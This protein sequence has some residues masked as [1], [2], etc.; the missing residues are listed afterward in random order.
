MEKTLKFITTATFLT[1]VIVIALF[2]SIVQAQQS[3]V[4]ITIRVHNIK[5]FNLPK[6]GGTITVN[7]YDENWK[8]LMSSSI[9]FQGGESYVTTSFTIP[10]SFNPSGR[11]WIE[12]SQTPNIGLKLTEYW[13]FKWIDTS[14][15]NVVEF[16][17]C[18]PYIKDIQLSKD[19]VSIGEEFTVTVK[20]K[21]PNYAKE[22][23][24]R[25]YFK[26]WLI[27]D[28]SKSYPYDYDITSGEYKIYYG[29]EKSIK[30]KLRLEKEGTYY[31]YAVLKGRWHWHSKNW[32]DTDQWVWYPSIEVIP[33]PGKLYVKLTSYDDDYHA[34]KVYID[35][36]YWGFVDSHPG[37]IKYSIDKEVSPG[38]HTVEIK[39]HDDDT[40][41]D[42]SKSLRKYVGSGQRIEYSFTIDEHLSSLIIKVFRPDHNTIIAGAKIV[43][44]TKDWHPLD[45]EYTDSRGSYIFYLKDGTYHAEVYYRDEFLGWVK[46]NNSYDIKVGNKGPVSLN[47]YQCLPNC[48]EQRHDIP[49]VIRG[50]PATMTIR[51][52]NFDSRQWRVKVYVI[53][54]KDKKA[55]WDNEGWTSEKVLKPGEV[56]EFKYT[57]TLAHYG[58]YYIWYKVYTYINNKWI[59]TDQWPWGLSFKVRGPDLI[60]EKIEV[61]GDRASGH[62]LTIRVTVKNI[63][64]ETAYNFYTNI[65]VDNRLFWRKNDKLEPGKS[66]TW[67]IPGIKDNKLNFRL[68]TGSYKIKAV[69]DAYNNSH[70]ENEDNNQKEYQ[71]TI[72]KAKWTIIAYL[73]AEAWEKG[74]ELDACLNDIISDF[75][76][77]GSN[78]YLTI[79]VLADW[80]GNGD[81]KCLFIGHNYEAI[82]RQNYE[83]NM[84][85]PNTLKDFL[86]M[87]REKFEAEKY[88]MV[89]T[90]HGGGS[91]F[92]CEKYPNS[93]DSM[94]GREFRKA[95]EEAKLKIDVLYIESCLM[96]N[97]DF[98]YTIA[99]S[100]YVK[101]LIASPILHPCAK[102]DIPLFADAAGPH[103]IVINYL[104]GNPDISPSNLASYIVDT[105]VHNWN[106]IGKY[107]RPMILVALDL[108]KIN[109]II[110]SLDNLARELYEN[111]YK[112]RTKINDANSSIIVYTWGR[113]ETIGTANL[114]QILDELEKHIDNDYVRSLIRSTRNSLNYAII[115][116]RGRNIRDELKG[117]FINWHWH[118]LPS[119][120]LSETYW[121]D[122]LHRQ[123]RSSTVY[124][125]FKD[126]DTNLFIKPD[127]CKVF[128]INDSKLIEAKYANV[129]ILDN[130]IVIENLNGSRLIPWTYKVL[131]YKNGFQVGEGEFRVNKR[132]STLNLNIFSYRRIKLTLITDYVGEFTC[133]S[134]SEI[135][136]KIYNHEGRLLYQG[137]TD[138][139][140]KIV[141]SLWP[142][143]HGGE[144]YKIEIQEVKKM[145]ENSRH[146]FDKWSDNARDIL[147][148]IK[149][150]QDITLVAHYKL[151]YYL[152]VE[153]PYGKVNGEGWYDRGS[154]AYVSLDKRIYPD[155][156]YG[157]NT[158]YVFEKWIDENT[159]EEFGNDYKK[160]KSI[161]MNKPRTIKAIWKPW[162]KLKVKTSPDISVNI[163][164]RYEHKTYTR[165]GEFIDFFKENS[166]VIVWT[167]E[168]YKTTNT[169]YK[170]REWS[171]D[172]SSNKLVIELTIDEP[173]TLTANY[174]TYYKLTVKTDPEGLSTPEISPYT[175]DGFY[176][177]DTQVTLTAKEIEGYKFNYW[178][179]NG[180]KVGK[181]QRTLSITMEKPYEVIAVYEKLLPD[182]LVKCE[183]PSEIEENTPFSIKV[184]IS[185]IG[186]ALTGPFNVLVRIKC[187]NAIIDERTI[188]INN[189]N[190]KQSIQTPINIKLPIGRYIFEIIADPD[191]RVDEIREDNNNCTFTIIAYYNLVIKAIDEENKELFIKVNIDGKEYTTPVTLSKLVEACH[192]V[193][194]TTIDN[195]SFI[196]WCKNGITYSTSNEINIS[197]GGTYVA[198]YGRAKDFRL[199]ANE[200][201]VYI[202]KAL[203]ENVTR[204]V[205]INATSINKY[206]GTITLSYSWINASPNIIVKLEPK[207]LNIPKDGFSLAN[208]TITVMP[209][210]F[211]GDYMLNITA[212]DGSIS[213]SILIKLIIEGEWVKYVP[214][215]EET[216]LELVCYPENKTYAVI[217]TFT[218]P[219]TGFKVDWRGLKKTGNSFIANTKVYQWTG[220]SAQVITSFSNKYVLGKL[221]PGVYTF[222]LASWNRTISSLTF[223]VNCTVSIKVSNNVGD[224][225]VNVYINGSK[226][227]SVNA[228][229]LINISL[230]PNT[231]L[232]I[233]VDKTIEVNK[234]YRLYCDINELSILVMSDRSVQFNYTKQY[235][236]QISISIKEGGIIT[237][238]GWYDE[239]S[240]ANVSISLNKGYRFKYW[241]LLPDNVT[242]TTMN[243]SI[244]MNSPKILIAYIEKIP[245]PTVLIESKSIELHEYC[246]IPIKVVNISNLGAYDIEIKYDPKVINVINIK[247]GDKPFDSPIYRINNTEGVVL[248]NQFMSTTGGF[249]GTIILAYLNIT[250][251]GKPGTSTLLNITIRS[252]VNATSGDEITPR[253][254]I[255][256]TINI[257]EFKPEVQIDLR[258]DI[259]EE[260]FI[261]LKVILNSTYEIP[262]GLG[263]YILNLTTSPNVVLVKAKGGASPFDKAPITNKIKNKIIID[264][265][266]SEKRGPK[267]KGLHL[268]K[269]LLRLNSSA[270][271][272]ITLNATELS[273]VSA[274][275]GKEYKAKISCKILQFLRGDANK[276]GRVSIADAMFIAQYLAGNR[277]ASHLNLLNAA[278]V[279]HD[280]NKGDKITIADAMFIAQYLAGLR[281]SKFNIKG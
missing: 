166:K 185:N 70:E 221:K 20:V 83:A 109:Q 102:K 101:I 135:L 198:L 169:K 220:I 193:V 95:L 94:L 152:K 218:F 24:D 232:K 258:V 17:R 45:D 196:E 27:V 272:V 275:T 192:V 1:I 229:S 252:L 279:K 117:P 8:F 78:R 53:I 138:A 34:V 241:K 65:Y 99:N 21:Y 268:M 274:S 82:I 29:G 187:D 32:W 12:V 194:P 49:E 174:D 163:H 36:K 180:E 259:D 132:G 214:K 51:V 4:I 16:Y 141:F 79:V 150:R 261:V 119:N 175:P 11:Y 278:S 239:G 98:A 251:I 222:N 210:T 124:I 33:P 100:G 61:E 76:K 253:K 156:W 62:P 37:K 188:P 115:K 158:I 209:D 153:S 116:V 186:E 145:N 211:P 129:H 269:L 219:H 71:F 147:R 264:S 201:H 85:D 204:R 84:G 81:T 131:F 247:G 107:L 18:T 66:F 143:L 35:G 197:S 181:G 172:T 105:F 120:D 254:V 139:T 88:Y 44:Y 42:Y 92:I 191:N 25:V 96:G 122:F 271:E 19:K 195:R 213:H 91:Y 67:V 69:V 151:Q 74:K 144:Y 277:P 245:I 203:N 10:T 262:G 238:E 75:K 257:I 280:G 240:L 77:I 2:V 234:T 190:P 39:W 157:K 235:L 57:F 15:G 108:T 5:E 60:V 165:K 281:D 106:D 256:A 47:F 22:V 224:Y 226:V 97:I 266:I 130:I 123:F 46:E 146:T 243:V 73:S 263:A 3:Y 26:V 136:V 159:N 125:S 140:G 248:I 127:L 260:G 110:N 48:W 142:A 228:L 236:L 182:I 30:F 59:L 189:L 164:V 215:P 177:K 54:D 103:D 178:L 154:Y 173:K 118:Y 225:N 212:S 167:D 63:G 52:K 233:S 23:S 171:G 176:L 56:G 148:T 80:S 223:T 242:Y 170:F 230:A 64:K 217:V 31:I 90:G 183:A 28:R 200:T 134:V 114:Y 270:K 244:N 205:I 58:V 86:I 14:K 93:D 246:L 38:Y 202:K 273:L 112:Y 68:T 227:G 43:L 128:Y 184:E 126:P 111:N 250:A 104:N 216:K 113:T 41:R 207:L 276:D 9:L 231:L 199:S 265:F 208:L 255:N 179:L 133:E 149:P 13:G 206:S 162:H 72:R 7:L 87:V 50:K 137:R 40:N 267:L 121:R 89:I 168:E 55:S 155:D 161:L 160:S 237:G 6:T 249:N